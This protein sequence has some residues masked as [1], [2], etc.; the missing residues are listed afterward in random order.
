MI[1]IVFS[2][3]C[4][5]VLNQ[6]ILIGFEWIL[7]KEL[8]SLGGADNV[9]KVVISTAVD[10]G[11][12]LAPLAVA[13]GGGG[14]CDVTEWSSAQGWGGCARGGGGTNAGEKESGVSERDITR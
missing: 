3:G 13:G 10:Q 8:P 11:L 9:N 1:D 12:L 4:E 7:E 5:P 14:G 6:R 2:Y